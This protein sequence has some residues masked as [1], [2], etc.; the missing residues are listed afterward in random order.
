MKYIIK[1]LYKAYDL[2]YSIALKDRVVIVESGP[3]EGM[4][5]LSKSVGSSL[6][7]KILGTY[8]SEI[9]KDIT[10]LP[11]FDL[12]LDIG[13][14]EGYYAVGLIHSGLCK[15]VIAWEITPE[16]RQ[17]CERLSA[18]NALSDMI[19]VKGKCTENE[20]ELVLQ[21]NYGKNILLIIDCEGF[22]ANLLNGIPFKYL[23]RVYLIIETHDFV[24]P[25]IHNSLKNLFSKTHYVSEI[26]PRRK[27][28]IKTKEGL[29]WPMS[30]LRSRFMWRLSTSERRPSGN[31]WLICAPNVLY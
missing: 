30:F 23:N 14:A 8:E 2:F 12:G 6:M 31:G 29:S 4:K 16:G 18:M 17:L 11:R 5:Y 21:E 13:P 15:N 25:G 20:L 19:E 24:S 27:S 7:P 9:H 1:L 10:N 22:E 26:F 3:F 28:F